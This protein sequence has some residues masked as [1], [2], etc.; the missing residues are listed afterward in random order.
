ME[1]GVISWNGFR[2]ETENQQIT[3]KKVFR[4][5]KYTGISRQ[6]HAIGCSTSERYEA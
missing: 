4:D 1:E 2:T 6:Q 3:I 5:L